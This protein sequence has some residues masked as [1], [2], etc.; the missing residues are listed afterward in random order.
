[1]H[2]IGRLV[3]HPLLANIQVSWVKM[4]GE[5]ARICLQSGANDLGG[6]LMEESITR[7]AGATHGQEMTPTQLQAIAV[8]AGRMPRQRTTLYGM[9]DEISSARARAHPALRR[10]H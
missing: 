4:G 1:M 9:V 3:L 10:L 7:A 8:D 2:A 6:T 5:G